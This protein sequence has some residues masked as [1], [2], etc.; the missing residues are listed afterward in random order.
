MSDPAAIAELYVGTPFRH[1]GRSA[2]GIDCI[3][4]LVKAFAPNIH[5]VNDYPERGSHRLLREV[6]AQMKLVNGPARGRAVVL[7]RRGAPGPRH[8]G[9]CTSTTHMVH[10]CAIAGFVH[11][12]PIENEE[13]VAH[14]F[15]EVA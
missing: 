11:V 10:A 15:W 2:S 1:Q 4:L 3:G 6:Q 9:V 7:M 12:L 8:V 13:R 5:D 14:S